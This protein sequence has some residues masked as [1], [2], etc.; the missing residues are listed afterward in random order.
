MSTSVLSR[1]GLTEAK[2]KDTE[3]NVAL[4]NTLRNMIS[5][6]DEKSVTLDPGMGTLIYNLATKLKKQEHIPPIY[7]LILERK[8]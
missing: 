7:G 8:V 2:I 6:A 3:A 5:E 4:S 1:L